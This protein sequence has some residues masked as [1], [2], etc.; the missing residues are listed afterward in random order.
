MARRSP[1]TQGQHDTAI[2]ALAAPLGGPK[3]VQHHHEPGR[4]EKPVGWGPGLLSGSDRLVESERQ[5]HCT[6]D[7]RGRN[8]RLGQ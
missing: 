6:L 3:Q 8:C 1:L 4:P 5:R 2:A 7:R